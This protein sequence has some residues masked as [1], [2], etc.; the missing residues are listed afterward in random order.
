MKHIQALLDSDISEF[1]VFFLFLH[2]DHL[3]IW[4]VDI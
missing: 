2:L 4:F 1:F 3:A